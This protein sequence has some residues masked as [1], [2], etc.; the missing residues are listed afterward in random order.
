V[1][2]ATRTNSRGDPRSAAWREGLPIFVTGGGANCDLYRRAIEM[3]HQ[4]L[5]QRLGSSSRFRFVEL[6]PLGTNV[7]VSAGDSGSRMTVAIGLTSDADSIARV[8][9]HRDIESITY[10]KKERVDHTE[11]YGD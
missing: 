5:K 4:E 8:V 6:N 9:P 1:I 7:P 2:N 3:V 11:L 10:G